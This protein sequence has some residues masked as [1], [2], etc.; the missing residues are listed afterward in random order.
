MD[1][2]Q[3]D[4]STI[5]IMR[6]TPTALR[7]ELSLNFTIV[8]P[9]ASLRRMQCLLNFATHQ[10][11]YVCRESHTTPII[12]LWLGLY[13]CCLPAWRSFFLQPP[14]GVSLSEEYRPV[15]WCKGLDIVRSTHTVTTCIVLVASCC[16][17]KDYNIFFDVSPCE[18]PVPCILH[19]HI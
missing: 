5:T 4:V 14:G 9:Y 11:M 16:I 1:F 15:E 6:V 7:E 10:Y 19:M 3:R 8:L 12:V 18:S 2:A 17:L 13:R